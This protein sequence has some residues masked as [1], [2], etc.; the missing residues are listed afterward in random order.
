MNKPPI[1]KVYEALTAIASKRITINE[2]EAIIHSSDNKKIYKV[3][4]QNNKYSSNDNATI[5][6]KYPGYPIIAVLLLQNKLKL[7][8]SIL[9]Y[10]KDINWH[11]LNEK[12]KRNY[13]LAILSVTEALDE[14]S[15]NKLKK[16]VEETYEELLKLKIEIVRNINK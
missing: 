13:N 4:W 11:Q 5:W 8:T 15:R 1:A 9:P 6:Q 7:D 2:N 12:Y 3:R 14:S 16:Y 10:V